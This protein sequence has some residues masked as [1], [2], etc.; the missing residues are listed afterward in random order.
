M[1]ANTHKMRS[2]NWKQLS[3]KIKIMGMP[4]CGAALIGV[5]VAMSHPTNVV[6]ATCNGKDCT[7]T[8][9]CPGE[10]Y[11][12]EVFGWKCSKTIANPHP[13]K[14]CEK[15]TD[16]TKTCSDDKSVKCG[17]S[18]NKKCSAPPAAPDCSNITY[19]LDIYS[20]GCATQ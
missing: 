8:A 17:Q 14:V 1:K 3:Q 7:K 19:S 12:F 18:G 15:T 4:L 9:S 6:A 20:N 2:V 13:G 11:V 16:T 5:L 10:C